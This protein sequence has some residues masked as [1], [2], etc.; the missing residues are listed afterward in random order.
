MI[1]TIVCDKADWLVR[2]ILP[3][4]EL[5][6]LNPIIAGG[7]MLSVYRAI[8]LHDTPDKWEGLRR[9]LERNPAK[10]K[11]DKFGDIDIWFNKDNPIHNDGHEYN[12]LMSDLEGVGIVAKAVGPLSDTPGLLPGNKLGLYRLNRVSRWANSFLCNT[13]KE[14]KPLSKEIQFIKKEFSSVRK[15]LES[16]DFI[17][18]S[19]A[20]FDGKLYYDDR[21]D[22]AFSSFELRLNNSSVYSKDSVAMKVFNAL[23]AFKYVNRYSLDFCEPLTEHIFKLYVDSKDIDYDAYKAHVIELEEHYGKTISSVNTLKDMV[24]SFHGTF[25]KFSKMKYFKKEYSLF[26]VDKEHLFPGLKK[27]IGGDSLAISN[28][29]KPNYYNAN[30]KCYLKSP[31]K[32]KSQFKVI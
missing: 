8:R 6:K 1:K 31:I 20:Y 26:L 18:C 23:R 22:E 29:I 24:T 30:I 32:F 11:L 12:W 9:V 17:N 3:S 27:L 25:L 19:V 2:C 4:D 21:I 5:L 28:E 16:F 14:S 7:S 13:T 15:L 10:A